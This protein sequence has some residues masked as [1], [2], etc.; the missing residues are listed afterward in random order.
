MLQKADLNRDGAI[1][2][3]EFQENRARQFERFDRNRDGYLTKDDVPRMARR[4]AGGGGGRM[5]ELIQAFDANRD[6]RLARDEFVRGPTLGF[7]R[8]DAD[9]NNRIDPHEMEAFRQA[10]AARGR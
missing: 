5:A 6:G 10:A 2:R 8:A 1:T 3:A 4:N 7:D 9:R